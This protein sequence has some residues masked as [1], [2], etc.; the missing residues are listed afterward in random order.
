MDEPDPLDFLRKRANELSSTGRFRTWPEIVDALHHEAHPLL[1]AR[2]T[3]ESE[4]VAMV[5]TRCRLAM[6]MRN[7]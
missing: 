2:I 4:F 3:K 5:E 6:R 7:A 1:V